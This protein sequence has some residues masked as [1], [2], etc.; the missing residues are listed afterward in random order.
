VYL[1]LVHH[2]GLT[3]R[4][5]LVPD[6]ARNGLPL[7]LAPLWPREFRKLFLGRTPGDRVAAIRLS[8]PGAVFYREPL[9]ITF[10]AAPR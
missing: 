9:A 4:V 3:W 2:S 10:S 8:G 5:R 6:T 1:D 7:D